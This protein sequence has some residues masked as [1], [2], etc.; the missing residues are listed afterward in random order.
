MSNKLLMIM[1]MKTPALAKARLSQVLPA[2]RR[3]DLAF[4]LFVRSQLF[5][6][7]RFAQVDR[8]VVTPSP[9]LKPLCEALGAACLLEA[10]M[11]GLNVAA[12]RGCRWAR[13]RGYGQVLL[14]P[15]DM[16]VW[17]VREIRLLL[18]MGQRH[19]VVIV[20][21]R[22]GGT[23]ALLLRMSAMAA[24][25]GRADGGLRFCYGPGSAMAHYGAASERGLS[26]VFCCLPNLS[27]DVDWPA[28][29]IETCRWP[30]R[31]RA[32]HRF[33]SVSTS[34]GMQ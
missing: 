6:A 10:D 3:E 31:V 5:W 15:A 7:R 28:D 11:A 22:D 17:C 30:C 27:R 34:P 19:E 21:S 14:M 26:V 23:N 16:A 9:F 33:A 8:L 32:M 1:P 12:A 4:T 24:D 20:P 25:V 2:H 29:Y 13:Q 18:D